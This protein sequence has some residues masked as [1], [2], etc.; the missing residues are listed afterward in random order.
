M[1]CV[2]AYVLYTVQYITSLSDRERSPS[3]KCF[4]K[5][6]TEL[7]L[8]KVIEESIR[9]F[10]LMRICSRSVLCVIIYVRVY[11]SNPLESLPIHGMIK[12]K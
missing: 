5:K 10:F 2:Q 6:V 4:K 12:N 9:D 11:V 3:S 1:C 7:L 8:F